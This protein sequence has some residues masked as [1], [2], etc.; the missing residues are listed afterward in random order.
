[1]MFYDFYEPIYLKCA[2]RRIRRF[3]SIP[4]F[5]VEVC[6]T[7]T[8]GGG[9]RGVTCAEDGGLQEEGVERT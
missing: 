2:R 9:G 3:Q 7:R 4:E 5:E 8:D 6:P 1:M